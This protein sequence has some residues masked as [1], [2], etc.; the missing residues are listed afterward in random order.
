MAT[1][2]R[3]GLMR[4][5]RYSGGKS[6]VN[7]KTASNL[8]EAVVAGIYLDGGMAEVRKFLDRFL[9]VTQTENHKTLLQEFV[10]ERTKT[11]PV[12]R[13]EERNGGYCCRV[14]ALGKKADGFGESKKAAE[15]EA[16]K[17]LFAK[18]NKELKK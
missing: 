3:A 5:L 17:K 8:F 4:F 15:T 16:A 6:N 14:S 18:L 10:Q 13:V 1:E 7:G 11:T 12:Y 9:S 2:E